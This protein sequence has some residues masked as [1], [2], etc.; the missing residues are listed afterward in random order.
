M[1]ENQKTNKAKTMK[2]GVLSR[3]YTFNRDAIDEE[4][5]TIEVS[6]SSEEPY[7]RWFGYE[8]LDHATK[9][10]DLSRLRN[11]G[12]VLVDHNYG[13][14][15][16]VV[17][18]VVIASD[19]K[20]RAKV[21]FAK[22]Q[23]AEQEWQDVLDGIRQHISVGY[24]VHEMVLEKKDKNGP[25]T[26]R[27]TKWE[28]Y[29]ISFVAVPADPT[30][31]VGRG[32]QNSE[33]EVV[34]HHE[35]SEEK[36]FEK[37]AKEKQESTEQSN[38]AQ[39]QTRQFSD[40]S[41]IQSDASRAERVRIREINAIV[42]KF[43]R[44]AFGEIGNQFVENGQSVDDFRK[45]VLEK[46][47]KPA[48]TQIP[49]PSAEIGLSKKETKQYSIVRA[50][51]AMASGNR[52]LAAFEMEASNA[53]ADML[54]VEAKGFYVPFDVLSR[55]VF[56]QQRDLNVGTASA[57]GNL[58]ATNLLA[59]SFIDLLRNKM[60]TMKLGAQMLS[61]LVGNIAIPR[62]TGGATAYWVGEGSAPTESQGTFD[63]V[64]MSPK[65]SGAFTDLTRRLLL[66]SSIDV[67]AFVRNDLAAVLALEMDRVGINGSGSSNQPR[68]ILNTSGI[69]AVVGGTN[70]AAPTWDHIVDL[71]TEVAVDNA[72]VGN[73]AYLTNTKVRGKLKKTE[74]FADTNGNP[75]FSDSKDTPLNGYAAGITN[76]V[77]SNLDKG[78]ATGVCSAI[79]FGN[80]NDLIYGQW[81]ALDILVDPYSASNSGTTRVV[82]LQD[83]DVAIR[84][85]VSFSAMV[86]A[87]TA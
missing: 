26:Y 80:F 49:V 40:V 18:D 30:V 48:A 65:T 70:G 54:G 3:D 78:T 12:A 52:K 4:N 2:L 46:M 84:H 44:D 17:E 66:Q 87:L 1:T 82:A 60:V 25:D 50:I 81:G 68:G 38:Q 64:T 83:V 77:P 33:F 28:P 41:V 85:A 13:A 34:I 58:V 21:R 6:F 86:D 51:H 71:E 32:Q 8:I 61:G 27:V 67:E 15:I 29:E 53:V 43:G 76:Q 59:S 69:G 23:R 56:G 75:V 22:N 5:R 47:G 37:D 45:V 74:K 7:L 36:M 35:D 55:D 14:Q 62:A 72:D 73:L 42:E 79:I 16:G 31:G 10:V 39:T 24:R 63:Q 9:S 57:G 19:R 20:G 11:A